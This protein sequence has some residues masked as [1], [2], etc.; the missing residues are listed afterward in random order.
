MYVESSPSST[1]QNSK[2]EEVSPYPSPILVSVQSPY[3]AAAFALGSINWCS[4][5]PEN[6]VCPGETVLATTFLTQDLRA[7]Q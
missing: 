2:A 6:V 5:F 3:H 7:L 1:K 4:T